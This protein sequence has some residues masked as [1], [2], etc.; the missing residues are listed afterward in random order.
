MEQETLDLFKTLTE[1]PGAPGNESA[2]RQFM[3]QELQKYS[4]EIIQ[5]HLGSVFG[6]RRDQEDGPTV[7]V[8]GHMDE[9][10]FMVTSITENGMIRFQTLGAGGA[11]CCWL[12]AYKF[13]RITVLSSVLLVQ[14]RHIY[15]MKIRNPNQ[16]TLKIC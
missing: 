1:L 4:D 10:G 5:D 14:F 15:W 3:K 9:V 11:R 16:W 2:V 12:N 8:A 7:M 6:V 13:I